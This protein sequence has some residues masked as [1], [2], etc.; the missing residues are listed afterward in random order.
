MEDTR[1]NA[2]PSALTT[3]SPG[4]GTTMANPAGAVAGQGSAVVPVPGADGA[5]PAPPRELGGP[6]GPDPTRYGDWER[7]GRCIDF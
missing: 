1:R 3:A 6:K 5:M 2:S 4:P 7:G